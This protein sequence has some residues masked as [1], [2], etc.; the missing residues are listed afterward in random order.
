MTQ[1]T[2][3]DPFANNYFDCVV[4]INVLDHVFDASLCMDKVISITKPG[5]IL[6]IGQDLSNKADIKNYDDKYGSD[7][8]GHPIKIGHEWLEKFLSQRFE[9]ILHKILP[10]ELGRDPDVHYGT[11]I[12][13][14]KK[15]P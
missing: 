4:M 13:A 12:F 11:F 7:G 3:Q 2:Y 6:L 1:V 15:I 10:R 5:G 9:N 14:G 8:I